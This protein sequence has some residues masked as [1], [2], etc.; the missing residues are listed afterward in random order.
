MQTC[1]KANYRGSYNY[2]DLKKTALAVVKDELIKIWKKLYEI[3]FCLFSIAINPLENLASTYA[4]PT[5]LR[6][7]ILAISSILFPFH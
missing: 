2:V 7:K 1:Q 6:L 4:S 3:W 5:V